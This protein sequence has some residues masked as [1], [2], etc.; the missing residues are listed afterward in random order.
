MA[1]ICDNTFFAHSE[2][3]ENLK[4]IYEFIGEHF[5]SDLEYYDGT[6]VEGYFTS[7]WVFPEELM[8][9]MFEAMPNKEDIYM[10][11]LSV[12]YG[13]DYVA[14]HKCDENGWYSVV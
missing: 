3:E 10:R 4:H 1:N 2:C 8:K 9:D 6:I 12:E 13:C 5:D 11:C 7:R 14:Y